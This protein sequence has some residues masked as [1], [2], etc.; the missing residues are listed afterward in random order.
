MIVPSALISRS[1]L[2]VSPRPAGGERHPIERHRLAAA[3]P[4]ATT[5]AR[6]A[7]DQQQPEHQHQDRDS[8]HPRRCHHRDSTHHRSNA[9]TASTTSQPPDADG[10]ARDPLRH[11]LPSHDAGRPRPTPPDSP[12]PAPARAR[13]R[14]ASGQ[15]TKSPISAADTRSAP[16]LPSFRRRIR[17]SSRQPLYQ[18]CDHAYTDRRYMPILRPYRRLP[19]CHRW[20]SS[21]AWRSNSTAAC[22]PRPPAPPTP[23]A[24]TPAT[25]CRAGY[26]QLIRTLGPVTAHD[27]ETLRERLTLAG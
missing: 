20:N 1:G 19:P 16:P 23:A 22:G 13:S 11:R 14:H 18:P 9:R 25:P 10:P 21:S 24:C 4:P 7:E 3:Q 5:H 26:E 8:G 27:L 17:R 6:A 15:N 2:P 12:A